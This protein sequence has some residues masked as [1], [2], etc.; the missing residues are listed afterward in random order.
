VLISPRE[1]PERRAVLQ[2]GVSE[3]TIL[4]GCAPIINLFSQDSEPVEL[5]TTRHE[6]PIVAD[7]R[8]RET[9]R[10]FSIDE[11]VAARPGSAEVLRFEPLY[12]FRHGSDGARPQTFWFATPHA[13]GWARDGDPDMYISFVDLSGRPTRPPSESVTARVT[14]F[15]G[16]L[17]SRLPFGDEGG[18]FVLP[19][20]GPVQKI[21]ALVK[22]TPVIRPPLGK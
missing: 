15:N 13:A 4:L 21:V 12:S 5:V 18:D 3:R 6:Y 7:A 2:A 14:S 19:G 9:T 20:G 11:V 1:R 8:R 17:P 10:I 16:D 22:P